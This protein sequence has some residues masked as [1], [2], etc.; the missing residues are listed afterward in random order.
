MADMTPSITCPSC[1]AANLPGSRFCS[2]C[3][4]PLATAPAPAESRKTVTILFCDATSS[5][6]LGERLDPESIRGLM[7][8]YFDVMREVIEFHGGALEKF[9]GDAVMAVFG[10]PAVHEDDALRACRAAV[11][12]RDRLAA[13][14]TRIREEQGAT[15]QWR[16]G[17]NTGVVVAGDA[18]RGQRIVTGD[19]VNVAARL[20]AAA[21]PGET[22]IGP[23]TYPL[24]RDQATTEAVE[25]LTLKGKAEPVP[26]WRLLGVEAEPHRR[27]RPMEA[28]LVGRKRPMRLLDEGFREAT[29]ERVCHLFTVLGVAG[30]G[31]SRLV[32]EFIG[33]VGDQ[34]QVAM[35]RCLAYGHGITYWPVSEAVRDGLELAEDDAPDTTMAR[36]RELLDAEPD[37]DRIAAI[38]GGLLGIEGSP[39][40]A[41]ETFWAIRKTFEAMARRKPLILVFDDIHWG[42]PTFLDLVDHIADWTRDAP[43]LLIAMARPELLEKRPAWGGGKR[44]VTTISLEP[45][46]EVES[47]EL[48]AS[49]LG[50]ADLPAELRHQI[51][52]AAEGNPL[53]VEELLGKLIDD[54]F[55]VASGDGWTAAGDLGTL[56][57]PSSIWALLAARLDGLSGEERAVL[58]RAAVEGKTFHRGAV[59]ELSPEPTRGEVRDRLTSLMR[60]ELVRPDQASFAGDEAYRFRHLLIRD[61][62]YQALAKQTRSEL[63]E[64]FATWLERVAAERVAEYE[65]II[66]YHLELAY[67]YRVELGPP[68]A[69]AGELARRAGTLLAEA[70]LRARRRGDVPATVDLLGRAVELLPQ[71][72]ARERRLLVWLAWT[73]YDHGEALRSE[74]VLLRAVAQ[75]DAAG[76]EGAAALAALTLVTVRNSTR[77][78]EASEMLRECE[79]LGRILERTGDVAGARL[80]EAWAAFALFAMGHAEEAAARAGALLASGPSDEPWYE[81][82][83]ANRG[84]ALVW[85][86][87]P[88][89]EAI[90]AIRAQVTL[91]AGL[92]YPGGSDRGIAMLEALHGRFAEARDALARAQSHLEELGNQALLTWCRATEGEIAHLAGE[93]DA[94]LQAKVEAYETMTASGD[95]AFASTLAVEVGAIFLDLGEAEK[96]WPYA[97]TAL[98][99]S[100]LDDVSSQAG[101]RGI[102][103]RVLSLRGEHEAAEALARQAES[104]MATTD[105]LRPHGDSLRHLAHVLHQAGKTEEGLAAA[106]QAA[107]LY[108]RKGATVLVDRT[109]RLIAEWSA[110]G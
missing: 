37:A 26:A 80:A 60:M 22:L 6:A 41:E 56:T 27:P 107:A 89:D 14:D 72:T 63:H 15:I 82:A 90:G 57:I 25:P 12:I 28:P 43:I 40:A 104:M 5:T 53:F 97:T 81:E 39:S 24:V 106:R 9:I 84:G 69:H 77:S 42:E 13:L 32:E 67:R 34:A 71:E 21:S 30:V 36:L 102:Q 66:G 38:V 1:G 19:A 110:E 109:E 93:L 101:G 2:T 85:G 68:D 52:A 20:E 35:G 23:E 7:T 99:T 92:G 75:A 98:E 83:A 105:Y 54:G 3:A 4:T 51:S 18:A 11:E 103:A 58:G 16:M 62:A 96:A 91:R 33:S 74:S 31:K 49:L 59:T 65:E 48:A 87:T 94:A 78:T 45:L 55:L 86:P 8:R 44:W 100:S 17:I 108:A 76:D 10:V 70:G 46:S 29:E 64:R 79:R 47:E 61:A 88:I 50:R 95:R 73:L